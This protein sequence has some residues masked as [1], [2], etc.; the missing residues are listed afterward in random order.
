MICWMRMLRGSAL[1]HVVSLFT[2][3]S[4]ETTEEH[5][6]EARLSPKRRRNNRK[7]ELVLQ[8]PVEVFN[9]V[10]NKIADICYC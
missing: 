6:L 3:I 7:L 2:I 9:Q 10:Q 4:G 1:E 5:T 8:L